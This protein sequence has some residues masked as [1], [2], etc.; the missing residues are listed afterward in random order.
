MSLRRVLAGCLGVIVLMTAN[1]AAAQVFIPS[2]QQVQD[3]VA[4]NTGHKCGDVKLVGGQLTGVDASL[5]PETANIASH[6]Q[7]SQFYGQFSA[8]LDV[9]GQPFFDQ[10]FNGHT[11][12]DK[13]YFDNI[14]TMFHDL[15]PV[16]IN[17]SLV[18]V[19]HSGSFTYDGTQALDASETLLGLRI[20]ASYAA[21]DTT[22]HVAL[23]DLTKFG[24][25]GFELVGT[26]PTRK[27]ALKNLGDAA[28]ALPTSEIADLGQSVLAFWARTQTTDPLA[29]NPASVQGIA[30]RNAMNLNTDDSV[31]ETETE[32][33]GA[34]G[35]TGVGQAGSWMIGFAYGRSFGYGYTNGGP[36]TNSVDAV[37]QKSWRV[38]QGDRSRLQL[39]VPVS[40]SD[41][42]GGQQLQTGLALGLE[43]PIIAGRW[44]VEPQVSW[45]VALS[46]KLQSMGHLV[47]AT[48]T[49]RYR[50]DGFGRGYFILGNMVG[51]S[52]TLS[53]GVIGMDLNP[54]LSNWIFRN[55]V[56][57]ELP[58]ERMVFGRGASVRASYVFTAFTGSPLAVEQFHELT[59]SF[60]V[61][62]REGQLHNT[63]EAFRIGAT[64]LV[65]AHYN[66]AA[67][68]FGFRF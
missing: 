41:A 36:D 48:V 4:E 57:Y 28:K 9:N 68:T 25:G 51:Y 45:G 7:L 18:D 42:Y 43:Q 5:C 40:Y 29:G 58:L 65:G 1:L 67:A 2:Y 32:T 56:A 47:V 49:S 19:G 64:I 63:F 13:A 21:N 15:F 12:Y 52:A 59:L 11:T 17:G 50:I 37:V 31:L 39:S 61:R 35:K 53:T 34:S 55:G 14:T 8:R 33:A 22:L 23:P 27:D 10:T 24:P 3:A 6:F 46:N 62:S 20:T 66:Q 54:H 26:G 44:S 60:G 16:G 30:V 38:F